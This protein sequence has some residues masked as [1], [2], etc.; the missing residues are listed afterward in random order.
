VLEG[1]GQGPGDWQDALSVSNICV[2]QHS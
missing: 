1:G 2:F